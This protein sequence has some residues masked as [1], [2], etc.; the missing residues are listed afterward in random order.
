MSTDAWGVT[1]GYEDALRVWRP[2]GDD[3]RAAVHTAMGVDPHDAPPDPGALV[4]IRR[5]EAPWLPCPAEVILEDGSR[6]SIERAP[7]DVH[8]HPAS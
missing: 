1:D 4:V 3:A 6:R 7:I 2:T 8:N 5:G